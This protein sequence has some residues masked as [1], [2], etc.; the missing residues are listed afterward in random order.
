MNRYCLGVCT[1]CNRWTVCMGQDWM[2]GSRWCSSCTIRNFFPMMQTSERQQQVI[3]VGFGIAFVTL[4]GK[5]RRLYE[6]F[7]ST[8]FIDNIR[9]Y[10]HEVILERIRRSK[11]TD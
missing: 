5:Y 11:T 7:N 8:P 4:H 2:G 3:M 10:E 6:R 1:A 9:N